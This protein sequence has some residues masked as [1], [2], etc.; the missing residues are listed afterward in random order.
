MNGWVAFAFLLGWL[1]GVTMSWR[2]ITR[3]RRAFNIKSKA[4]DRLNQ[5]LHEAGDVQIEIP[6]DRKKTDKPLH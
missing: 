6:N 2:A 4:L 1:V 3:S 5:A